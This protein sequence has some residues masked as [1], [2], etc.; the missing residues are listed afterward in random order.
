MLAR[1][2]TRLLS[3]YT[4]F[5]RLPLTVVIPTYRPTSAVVELVRTVKDIAEQVLVSDDASPCTFDPIIR[6]I[7]SLAPIT[8]HS[9][10]AGIARALNEG[11]RAAQDVGHQWLLT[12]DQDSQVDEGYVRAL[13]GAAEQLGAGAGAGDV[14]VVAPQHIRVSDQLVSYPE[15]L[16]SERHLMTTH[17]VFQ[18]GALWNVGALRSAGG[19]DETLG[20]DAV[21]AAACLRLR[22]RGYLVI[23]AQDVAL[24]HGWGDAQFIIVGGRSIAITH[25]SAERRLTMVRNRLRLAPA[26][27]RQSP[28]HGL[29]TMRRLAVG[30]A[31]A[32]VREKGRRKK[33]GA[34]VA[35]LRGA[36]KR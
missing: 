16:D 14:G 22:E 21:D 15:Y 35:G 19:F 3:T 23:L 27:F 5:V 36:V 20:M 28:I 6:E 8:V 12:I 31:L 25:H 26:E 11:L 4:P 33:F 32:L 9:T 30:T 2:G 18:S 13:W 29:R 17:E 24:E 34:T 10:N 1:E 7:S